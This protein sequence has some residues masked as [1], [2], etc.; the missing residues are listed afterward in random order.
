MS[1]AMTTV[2]TIASVIAAIG[3]IWERGHWWRT[4]PRTAVAVDFRPSPLPE[5]MRKAPWEGRITNAGT[6]EIRGVQL[7]GAGCV[8][9][10]DPADGQAIPPRS[11]ADFDVHVEDDDLPLA[12]VLIT[13]TTPSNRRRDHAT[14]FPLQQEGELGRVRE[15]Q[16]GRTAVRRRAALIANA[17]IPSPVSSA[18]GRAT[19]GMRQVGRQV[20]L[21]FPRLLPTWIRRSVARLFRVEPGPVALAAM[22]L[23][24]SVK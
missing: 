1:N 11:H 23:P 10:P 12:W 14:W 16:L 9:N 22:E 18:V 20:P 4:R 13:W 3:I 21:R 24:P 6:E 7:L 17:Q 8:A 15:R 2:G 5:L 19:F